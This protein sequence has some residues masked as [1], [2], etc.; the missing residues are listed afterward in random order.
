M[1]KFVINIQNQS[2]PI[3]ASQVTHLEIYRLSSG[4]SIDIYFVS[5]EMISWNFETE[6]QLD[7]AITDIRD[8]ING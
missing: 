1:P 2:S 6:Q 7:S 4:Y 8:G 3:N 5:G